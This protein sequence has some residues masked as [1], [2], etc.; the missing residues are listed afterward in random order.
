[1]VK[2]QA[3]DHRVGK[4]Q[5]PGPGHACSAVSTRG[6][7]EASFYLNPPH[8]HHED[9]PGLSVSQ[10][11]CPGPNPSSFSQGLSHHQPLHSPLPK[12]CED[13]KRSPQVHHQVIAF[14]SPPPASG[15]SCGEPTLSRVGKTQSRQFLVATPERSKRSPAGRRLRSGN[16]GPNRW[17]PL[18]GGARAGGGSAA[19]S[20]PGWR[21]AAALN[22]KID[23]LTGRC[24]QRQ[25][26]SSAAR[27]HL[28]GAA[29]SILA[30]L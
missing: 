29:A 17:R 1:M 23:L 12:H 22:C 30:P 8:P 18:R 3:Q 2:I 28:R 5:E 25:M 13:P 10:R 21:E 27:A 15:L 4:C 7:G 14:L 6:W 26:E 11:P 19:A 9:S 24:E 16:P 20:V